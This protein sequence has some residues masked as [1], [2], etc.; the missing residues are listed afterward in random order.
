M[1]I[2]IDNIAYGGY[3]VGRING[4]AVFVNNAIPG[5]EMAIEV[6]DERK[7]FSFA[8]CKEVLKPSDKRINP[9][10]C[11]F[12]ICGGC[13][14]LNLE[15]SDE[16]ESKIKIIRDHLKRIALI[17][18]KV[19]INI[20]SDERYHYRSHCNIKCDGIIKGFHSKN[21]NRIVPFPASGCL[22]ISDKLINGIELLNTRDVAGD[23]KLAEDWKGNIFNN[24]DKY[25]VI[26][27][28]TG[29]YY[30]RRN[31]NSF[32]QSN[33][34][35]RKKMSDLVCDYS[36]LTENDEFTDICAGCG[37]LTIP[38]SK[39][40]SHGT[41]YDIDHT[42]IKFAIDNS[43]LNNCNNLKFF[44]VSESDIN[45]VRINPKTVIVD[46]PRNGI[47]KKG[48]WTINS[49][50]PDIIVYVSCNPSTYSRD[51]VD[52]LKN[53]YKLEKLTMIDMFPCTYHI[54]L[55]SKLVKIKGAHKV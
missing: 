49:M 19:N 27:E 44:P 8:V 34:F 40:S 28:K 24:Q 3:G 52:F 12:E 31:V 5:D 7:S 18:D 26:E 16:I 17:E 1:K 20:I 23:L 38:L 47:S 54:E 46:P 53:G 50:N 48:R 41:G 13:S 37:F 2:K 11:N 15:Y 30:F 4:K 6:Y 33:R 55:I 10:C 21:S 42:S 32:F 51:I 36:E 14:Y 9:L 39:I 22:L 35:L 25:S 43:L 45:P 29:D